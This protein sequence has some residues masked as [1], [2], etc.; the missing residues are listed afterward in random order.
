MSN[1]TRLYRY[2]LD[3]ADG[4][5]PVPCGALN[6]ED[7]SVV[8]KDVPPALA[9]FLATLK[10][11]DPATRKPVGVEDGQVWLDLLPDYFSHSQKY[12][13]IAD[14]AT[15]PVAGKASQRETA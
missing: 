3:P 9:S 13:A 2:A 15:V 10:L 1:P 5:V 7:G 4:I 8:A 6:V 14:P 11:L 12:E